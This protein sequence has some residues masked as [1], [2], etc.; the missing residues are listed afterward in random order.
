MNECAVPPGSETHAQLR[1][2]PSH[3]NTS[4]DFPGVVKVRMSEFMWEAAFWCVR[5]RE[6]TRAFSMQPSGASGGRIFPGA[7]SVLLESF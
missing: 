5:M 3:C 4:E 6:F 1:K 2:K 7:I